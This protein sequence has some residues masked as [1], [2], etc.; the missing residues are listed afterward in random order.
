M[1]VGKYDITVE[2]PAFAALATV[3]ALI[4]VLMLSLLF[5]LLFVHTPIGVVGKIFYSVIFISL[6]IVSA[7]VAFLNSTIGFRVTRHNNPLL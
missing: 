2:E 6:S 4:P 7:H 5:I 1:N 3:L